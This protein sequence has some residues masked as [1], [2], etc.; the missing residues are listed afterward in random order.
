MWFVLVFIELKYLGVTNHFSQTQ[1]VFTISL[2]KF[3]SLT[4]YRVIPCVF[5]SFKT[6]KYF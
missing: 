3:E 5:K 6:V 1:R 2:M 4:F